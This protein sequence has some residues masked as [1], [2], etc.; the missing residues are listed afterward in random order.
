MPAAIAV[1][2]DGSPSSRRAI[3]WAADEA[4]LR[5][6][7]L[8]IV[9]VH[10]TL[11]APPPPA[12]DEPDPS[13][14]R[15]AV[16]DMLNAAK[17]DLAERSPRLKVEAELIS[18]AT[19]GAGLVA[20]SDR[21]ELLVL[22]ERGEGGFAGI[23]V[24]STSTQVSA[25]ARCP[26]VVVRGPGGETGPN[27]GRVVIGVDESEHSREAVRFGL[28]EA[29]LYQVPATLV[30]AWRHPMATRDGYLASGLGDRQA[31]ADRALTTISEAL[32]GIHE[33]FPDVPVKR[34]AV[35]GGARQVLL[36]Q[37]MGARML[38]VGSRGHGG[39][40]GLLLGSTSQAL[41]HHADAPVAIV[42]SAR[43]TTP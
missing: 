38:V 19:A 1:G 13:A 8:I 15:Q 23:L 39:F 17:R 16:R 5:D 35:H 26:V 6:R 9:T 20:G 41:L 28:R 29:R 4:R 32:S 27:A 36:D 34:M 10:L 33:D 25:H 43:P 21:W 40:A 30:H 14:D 18:A 31:M 12:E 2:Y 37:S 11:S 7:E 3:D 22:G 24:G 42:R